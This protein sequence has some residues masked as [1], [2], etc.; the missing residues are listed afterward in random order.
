MRPGLVVVARA[1]DKRWRA[2]EAAR[3]ALALPPFFW[4]DWLEVLDEPGLL[5]ERGN[6]GDWLRVE[7][8]G[9][10]GAVW[11]RLA[12]LGG[13]AEIVP[14][15]QWR[16]GRCWAAGLAWALGAVA[17]ASPHL[18]P[19]HPHAGAMTDKVACQARLE[20]A[21]VPVPPA[22]AAPATSTALRE[23]LGARGWRRAFVKP[24]WGSSAAGV[25]AWERGAHGEQITAPA[26][27]VGG[28][29][30]NDKRLARFRS[31]AE[32][33]QLLG[34]VLGDGAIVQRWV[35]KATTGAQDRSRGGPFDVRV[36]VVDGEVAHRVARVGR[37][38]IT[39][40]HLD[41][42]RAPAQALLDAL[43]PRASAAVDDVA[44]AAAAVFP[45]HHTLG[46]D[47]A[48]DAS[49]RA[50]VLEC[51]AWGDHLPGLAHDGLDPQAFQLRALLGSPA[52][53]A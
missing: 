21:G 11:H 52:G 49:G 17:A 27:L 22:F 10:D 36:L 12:A 18:R 53:A 48:V 26:R 45:G 16:P 32:L 29:I 50:F 38:P 28:R 24:R 5:R 43:G 42:V 6:P 15:G 34:P 20:A 4:V 40:L 8:P 25:L 9:A 13:G 41:A 1:G 46:V 33:E 35:P 2:L 39:N 37:G 30:L 44:R 3:Q 7:S 47:V 31:P 51:N 19:T 23:A 14:D